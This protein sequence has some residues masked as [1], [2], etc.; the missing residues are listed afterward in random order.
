VDNASWLRH[1]NVKINLTSN[2]VDHPILNMREFNVLYSRSSTIGSPTIA[3][4]AGGK[5]TMR[6][7]DFTSDS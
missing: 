5:G 7:A 6:G 4:K 3:R 2:I 1:D